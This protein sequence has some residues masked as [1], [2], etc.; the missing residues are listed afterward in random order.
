MISQRGIEPNP[1]KIRALQDMRE[2]T[3]YKDIQKLAG[4]LAALG[5]FISRS[6]DRSLPFFKKLRQTNRE[7]FEWNEECSQA[8]K[9]LREYLGSPK[10]LSRPEPG[11]QLQ[12]YLAVSE[13]AVSKVLVKDENQI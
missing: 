8:F 6:G 4:R 13:G 7:K 1:D 12:L 11:E 2:P 3:S 10:L 9:E 5:R